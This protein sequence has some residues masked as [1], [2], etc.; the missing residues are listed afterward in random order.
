MYLKQRILKFEAISVK[1]FE[2]LDNRLIHSL[3]LRKHSGQREDK[4]NETKKG[5]K[6]EYSGD[7]GRV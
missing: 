6:V 7:D 5:G 2:I 3:E 4:R 1:T